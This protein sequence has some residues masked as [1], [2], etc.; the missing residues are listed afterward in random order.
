MAIKS[1]DVFDLS[2]RKCYI[3]VNNKD[4]YDR[5]VEIEYVYD[6][7]YYGVNVIKKLREVKGMRQDREE[8]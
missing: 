2:R 7:G 8:V 3:F 5:E 4:K 1:F 6:S